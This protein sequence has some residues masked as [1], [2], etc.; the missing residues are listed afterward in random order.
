MDFV[1]V[2]GGF[3]GWVELHPG[4][5]SWVQAVGSVIALI[6]AV[7][8]PYRSRELDRK[9]AEDNRVSMLTVLL[10]DAEQITFACSSEKELE[11]TKVRLDTFISRLNSFLGG[12]NSLLVARSALRLRSEA[13]EFRIVL[14]DNW[15]SVLFTSR[16]A[17]L[18]KTI[19]EESIRLLQPRP[20]LLKTLRPAK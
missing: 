17:Q 1:A 4:L 14:D 20:H 13:E 19:H 6:F 3:L 7:Y 11:K 18:L 15:A 12:E 5:A 8:L 2:W 10:T 16:K 9:Q